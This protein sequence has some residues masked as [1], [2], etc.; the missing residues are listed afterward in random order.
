[1]A[2][3]FIARA[4]CAAIALVAGAA[5]AQEQ[6]PSKVVRVVAPATGGGSDVV[7]RIIAPGLSSRLGQQVIID[8]RGAIS[9]EIVAQSPPDGYTLLANGSPMWLLPLMRPVPYDPMRDFAPITLAISS[10]SMLVTHPSLPVKSVR[11]L[12]ALARAKPGQI[13]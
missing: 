12:L 2:S 1:E 13:N 3:R 4:L 8:N 11:E 7:A 5:F 6:Y 9:T 10:P